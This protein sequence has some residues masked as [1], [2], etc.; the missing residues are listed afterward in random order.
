MSRKR[1]ILFIDRDGTLIREP[2]D[3]QIDSYEKLELVENVIPALLR[4]RDVGFEF[5]M[6]S[7]QDGLGT[8]HFPQE[9]FDGPHRLLMNVLN[10]QG[11]EFAD[12]LIDPSRPEENSPNRKPGIGLVLNYLKSGE[13]DLANSCVIGDRDADMQLAENMGIAGIRFGNP[14][15]DWLEVSQQ[16]IGRPRSADVERNTNETKIC[17]HVDLDG[18]S[19]GEDRIA[20][21]IGFFDHMLEQ[22]ARHG[23]FAMQLE[24]QGDLHIDPHHTIEDVG[25][26]IGQALDRALGD[27]RGIGR[28]GFLLAMDE[29]QA[30]VAID[31]SGRPVFVQRGEF[32]TDR[33]GDF[34]TEM[35]SHFFQSLS[36]TLRAAIHIEFRGENNHH[37]IEGIFKGVGRALRP[38]LARVGS[39]LPSTKGVL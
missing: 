30:N 24:C 27:R 38:A 33:V 15:P 34:P 25:L 8:E 37:M 29:A 1:K 13:L 9:H 18:T 32:T 4:L 22:L 28:Y 17:V 7:N 2:L 14:G 3:E 16:I 23:G 5:V 35:V 20:T 31:L 26:A 6:V 36:Q 21:G 19:S 12:V 39:D 11:I 10:S